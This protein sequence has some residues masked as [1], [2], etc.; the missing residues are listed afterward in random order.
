MLFSEA[1]LGLHSA[2]DDDDDV[3]DQQQ[4]NDSSIISGSLTIVP[5]GIDPYQFDFRKGKSTANAIF[6][7]IDRLSDAVDRSRFAVAVGLLSCNLSSA[8]ETVNYD[9]LI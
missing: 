4:T 1:G 9:I 3:E 2:H 8:F 7:L 5:S 6:D